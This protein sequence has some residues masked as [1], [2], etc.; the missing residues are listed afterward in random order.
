MATSHNVRLKVR[1]HASVRARYG[2]EAELRLQSA[3]SL[4]RDGQCVRQ[5]EATWGDPTIFPPKLSVFFFNCHN[6]FFLSSVQII[7][8]PACCLLCVL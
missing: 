7:F 5:Q 8:I 4:N 2:Y 3:T 6:F 1:L